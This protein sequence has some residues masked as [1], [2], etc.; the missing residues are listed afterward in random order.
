MSFPTGS[1]SIRPARCILFAAVFERKG[2]ACGW[3][4]GGREHRRLCWTACLAMATGLSNKTKTTHVSRLTMSDFA[5]IQ[6]QQV[7]LHPGLN[8]ITGESGSGKSV[9]IEAMALLLLGASASES[10]IRPPSSTATLEALI[11]ISPTDRDVFKELVSRINGGLHGEIKSASESESINAGLTIAV[12]RKI[13][14]GASGVRSQCYLNDSP[15]SLKV[16]KELGRA[17]VDVNGQH[18]SQTV[19][20]AGT[21]LALLDR[22][23]GI[24]SQVDS[25][26]KLV[27]ELES[28]IRTVRSLEELDEEGRKE[29]LQGL[30]DEV[31]ALDV[32]PNEDVMIRQQLRQLEARRDAAER[33][34]LVSTGLGSDEGGIGFLLMDLERQIRSVLSQEQRALEQSEDDRFQNTTQSMLLLEE[35]LTRMKAA[36]AG[37]EDA[38][39]AV[40][41]YSR[42][43]TFSH[44]EYEELSNRS[45]QLRRLLRRY[46]AVDVEEILERARK[47]SDA[48]DEYYRLYADKGA[49]EV[50]AG[51][52]KQSLIVT[53][54]YISQQRKEAS[55]RLSEEVM[56]SL[57]ELGMGRCRFEAVVHSL[58]ESKYSKTSG[59]M[60]HLDNEGQLYHLSP[61]SGLDSVEFKFAAGP[62]E[63]LRPLA[64]VASGGEAA[65]IMLAIK[66]ASVFL[67][68]NE[69]QR[70]MHSPSVLVFD[71]IDSG[72]GARLGSAMGKTL[73]SVASSG[74]AQ[75]VCVSHL[76]QVAAHAERHI[77]V[78][79]AESEDGR[80][81]TEFK[82]LEDE[83]ERLAELAA[84]MGSSV[85]AAEAVFQSTGLKSMS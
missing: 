71:E 19:R 20:D 54:M 36:Q 80:V 69:T 66:A 28:V 34:S 57:V 14:A 77:C 75:V 6:H 25:F 84:M 31:T 17:L 82:V 48:L 44:A 67:C 21:Q 11:S 4:A 85:E 30:V 38:K 18:A 52:L 26:R 27:K 2:R 53:A 74:G 72:V 33:C 35:A 47:A 76:L 9:L 51:E 32:Q 45:Q 29:V 50:R 22:I 70:S 79:K 1:V 78:R 64:T 59:D 61:Q 63:E 16:L 62:G 3:L 83:D 7:D 81:T 37:L 65:R 49:L 42:M 10:M 55:R 15:T 8:V 39:E 5:L 41:E 60:L 23:G 13:S 24:E 43:A 73:R 58:Q 46:D 12:K 68:S 40:V 56:A